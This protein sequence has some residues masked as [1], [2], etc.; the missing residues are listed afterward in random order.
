[1]SGKYIIGS[2]LGTCAVAYVA[3]YYISDK[4]IFGGKVYVS[5]SLYFLP[6]V[7]LQFNITLAF[8]QALLL[9]LF[10]TKNGGKRLIRSSRH[11]LGLQVP[12]W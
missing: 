9:G 12:R 10:L 2:L 1:M 11:G 4:K 5:L 3:D 8:E 7:L 6:F